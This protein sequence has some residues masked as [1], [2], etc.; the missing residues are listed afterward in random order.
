MTENKPPEE[1]DYI[2]ITDPGG[3]KIRYPRKEVKKVEPGIA[4]GAN[5]LTERG[6]QPREKFNLPPEGSLQS[7][8]TLGP[9][10]K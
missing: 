3:K 7:T 8:P 4:F 6:A 2:E 9:R 1:N 5:E 10:K